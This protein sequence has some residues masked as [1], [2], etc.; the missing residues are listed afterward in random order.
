MAAYKDGLATSTFAVKD[1]VPT[2]WSGRI[3]S[4]LNDKR[5]LSS[6]CTREYEGQI[7]GYG[8]TVKVNG[9]GRIAV[10]DYIIDTD[11][12]YEAATDSVLSVVVDGAKYWAF[13]VEDIAKAQAKPE[14]VNELTKEAAQSIAK[15]TERYLYLNM[16]RAAEY[17]TADEWGQKGGS[18]ST[19]GGVINLNDTTNS[20]EA[21][22]KVYDKLVDVGVRLDDM[23]APDDGRFIVVP[24]FLHGY[25]LKDSR[26]ISAGQDPSNSIKA[27]GKLGNIAGFDVYKM[28]RGYFGRTQTTNFDKGFTALDEATFA[29]AYGVDSQEGTIVSDLGASGIGPAGTDTTDYDDYRC[30]AGVKGAYAYVEQM[31]KT[32]RLR[33]QTKFADAVRGLIVF[34]GGAIRPNWLVTAAVDD[35]SVSD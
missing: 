14:F 21:S 20:L 31:T 23:L 30:L 1:F 35:P 10:S 5:V 24:S 22:N 19:N 16:V 4:N 33:M 28:P 26:F 18:S 3:L 29:T 6:L 9:V 12:S 7:S 2:I 15:E 13:R 25:L 8:D 34:G 32:E 27:N 17:D 11:I